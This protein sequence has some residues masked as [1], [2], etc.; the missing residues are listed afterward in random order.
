MNSLKDTALESNPYLR[1]NLDGGDLSSDA[2]LLLIKEFA[3]KIGLVKRATP[4]FFDTH[5]Q[6]SIRRIRPVILRTLY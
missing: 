1:I 5:S 6:A 2:G 3:E 4:T